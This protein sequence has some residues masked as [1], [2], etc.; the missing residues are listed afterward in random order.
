[1]QFF[2]FPEFS[3]NAL[4]DTVADLSSSSN[5]SGAT[6]TPEESFSSTSAPFGKLNL[7]E[8]YVEKNKN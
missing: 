2:F 3:M 4:K 8:T 5:M 1:M 7:A 6:S